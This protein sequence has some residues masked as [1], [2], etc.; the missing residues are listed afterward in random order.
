MGSLVSGSG[1]AATCALG[2]VT[3]YVASGVPGWASNRW[4]VWSVFGAL[5]AASLTLG[6]IGRRLDVA[7]PTGT[8]GPVGLVPLARVLGGGMSSSLRAPH[9]AVPVRGR[10]G[11]LE[12]LRRLLA[13]PQ[14]RYAVL[15]GVGGIGKTTLAAALAGVARAEGRAV[16]WI[17]WRTP[18]ELAE[19]LI[20]T[21][22]ACGLPEAR[23]EE[24][25]AGRAG[26]PDVV[27]EQLERSGRWLLVLDNVDAPREVGPDG[28]DVASYRGWIR[29]SRRG[30]LLV[31]SR[32]TD[33][34][35]WGPQAVVRRIA[36]L[37]AAAGGQ[38][39]SDLAADAG[40]TD[41]A[42]A[43]A[44]RLGGLPLALHAVGRYLAAPGSRHR[45]FSAYADALD[46]QLGTLLAAAPATSGDAA[47]GRSLVRRTWELSLDQLAADGVPL[48][49]PVLRLLSLLALSPVP[50][51]LLT[52]D[53]VAEAVGEPAG[54]VELE[55]ALNGLHTYGLVDTPTRQDG[56]RV[57]GQV[58]LHP[59]VREITAHAHTVEAVDPDRYRRALG[60]RLTR[61]A[62]EVTGA[63]TAGW[64]GARLLAPHLLGAAE[65]AVN[66][67]NAELAD[68]VDRLSRFLDEAGDY[69]SA[70]QLSQAAAPINDRALGPHHPA[71]LRGR[72]TLADVLDRLGRYREAADLHRQVLAAREQVL[73]ADDPATVRSRNDLANALDHLGHHQE[74]AD[75][76]QAV[77]TVRERAL[78]P[79]HCD[80][81]RSR[82]DLA[83]ALDHLRRHQEAADLHREVLAVRER[84][85]GPDHPDTLHSRNN[86]GLALGYLGRHQEA[87]DLHRQALTD[88][89]RVLG[90]EHPDTMNSRNNLGLA[91]D[92]LGHHQDAAD[93]HGEVLAAYERVLGPDHPDTLHSRNNLGL[94]LH[95]L[96]RHREAAELHRRTLA[97]YEHLL[98]PDHPTTVHSRTNLAAASEAAEHAARG[99]GL[100]RG[101]RARVGA[102][103]WVLW[104]RRS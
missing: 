35:V 69:S 20:R 27:W 25:R 59:L 54:E 13:R 29:P 76:H 100:A 86:L 65:L 32:N 10:D 50:V 62:R 48:A 4:V 102:G 37:A 24:A 101:T 17:R 72:S 99:A 73:G 9:A 1:A 83:N 89:E 88:Y 81:V 49:R 7:E 38:V 44:D 53:L 34:A 52:P 46:T 60:T 33:P 96:G 78:G 84:V 90:A 63:G 14:G 71:T 6:L 80:T 23:L 82:S 58:T 12:A 42:R 57:L 67:R 85:L 47:A 56:Q 103:R 15:C 87:A 94:A 11:E 97:S 66:E 61:A 18:E 55:A 91:L 21:A 26:L 43:L 19:Q 5:A 30:L 70:L 39:L 104:P 36:P 68:A 92:D 40:T 45:A 95:H 22:L 98:G 93:L 79:E 77:L 64:D 41:E 31:T 2:V 3:N 74:A 8:G 75:L 51:S 16:F 28:E